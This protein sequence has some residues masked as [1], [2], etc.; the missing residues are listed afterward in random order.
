MT[1][2]D[3]DVPIKEYDDLFRRINFIPPDLMSIVHGIRNT[4]KKHN[5]AGLF[6]N[7]ISVLNCLM[8]LETRNNVVWHYLNKGT[9]DEPDKA[10]FDSNSQS[11]RAGFKAYYFNR[12]ILRAKGQVAADL[13]RWSP[14]LYG[15]PHPNIRGLQSCAYH[16]SAAMEWPDI[17]R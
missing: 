11:R 7:I 5:Q 14:I 6:D 4:L 16:P 17:A 3:N 12:V 2:R 9:H 10:E 1:E 13:V 8:G 15:V